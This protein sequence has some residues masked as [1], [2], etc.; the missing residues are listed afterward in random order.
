MDKYA[1]DVYNNLELQ[2]RA[3]LIAELTDMFP[4]TNPEYIRTR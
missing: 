1:H 3:K 2:A 4:Q